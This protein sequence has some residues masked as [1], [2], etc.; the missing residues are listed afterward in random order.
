MILNFYLFKEMLQAF[1]GTLLVLLLII[2]GGTVARLLGSVSDGQ[3]PADALGILVFIGSVEGAVQLAPVALLIGMM[4]AF[5]RLYRDNEISAI[6]AS[7]LGPKKLLQAMLILLIP[8]TFIL[9]YSVLYFLPSLKSYQQE[10]TT[11]IKQR[12][13]A[14]G[15]P[16]GEFI[17]IRSKDREFTIFVEK[18][19]E[20]NVVMTNFFL[21]LREPNAGRTM[22]ASKA[23]LFIDQKSGDRVLQIDNGSR[24]DQ[25]KTDNTFT[26]F[27]FAEHGIRVPPLNSIINE[28]LAAKTTSELLIS[29]DI[30]YSAELHWRFGIILSA[31]IMALLAFPLSY[32]TPRQ[33]R[34]GKL[35]WGILLYAIYANLLITG[36]SLLEDGKILSEF[37]LWWA[38]FPFLIL[39]IGML[40]HRYGWLK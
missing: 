33:G 38:H 11:E 15:I 10:I 37:G 1:V 22:L 27:K 13:E 5:G 9:A 16:A 25:N 36:K 30:K 17:H 39:S 6:H 2:V 18:L 20:K 7:G 24:Y 34:F 19:D 14:S 31:P 4:L 3:L 32:T 23:V 40:W 21:H 12:P 28:R 26:I 29:K 8:L 35:A